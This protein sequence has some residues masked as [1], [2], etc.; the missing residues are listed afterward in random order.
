VAKSAAKIA[1]SIDRELLV[2][3]ERLRRSTGESRS[4]I[5]ARGMRLLLRMEARAARVAEY[6]EAYRRAPETV[7]DVRGARALSRRALAHLPWDDG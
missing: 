4:A 7:A 1:I 5:V 6:V 3:A 2:K